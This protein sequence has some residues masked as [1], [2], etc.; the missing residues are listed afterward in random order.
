MTDTTEKEANMQEETAIQ[1]VSA[2]PGTPR[3]LAKL[4]RRILRKEDQVTP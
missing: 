3:H 1:A 4:H 2:M